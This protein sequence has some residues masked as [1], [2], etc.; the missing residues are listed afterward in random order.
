MVRQTRSYRSWFDLILEDPVGTT[1]LGFPYLTY[2]Q[3][4]IF[5][6][7]LLVYLITRRNMPRE[8][9][10]IIVGVWASYQSGVFHQRRRQMRE[11]KD[12]GHGFS[13]RYYG[14]GW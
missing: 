7:L 14:P 8:L 4:H 13:Q 1:S 11:W 10:L 5:S 12:V 6:G 2:Q 9:A 3:I